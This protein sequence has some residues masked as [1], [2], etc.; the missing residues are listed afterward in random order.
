MATQALIGLA[1]YD[2]V[3]TDIVSMTN[4]NSLYPATNLQTIDPQQV[5]KATGTSSTITFIHGT[6]QRPVGLSIHNHKLAGA[7]VTFAGQ[8]VTIPAR[9]SDGQC[10]NAWLDLRA[11]SIPNTTQHQ[12]VISGASSG[13]GIGRVCI[14]TTLTLLNYQ[15]GSGDVE[16]DVEW[17]STREQGYYGANLIYDR[18]VRL[19]EVKGKTR[20]GTDQA[21]LY[22]VMQAS[23]GQY[24]PFLF[25]PEATAND[26]W[27]ATA[28]KPNLTWQQRTS[29]GK[30]ME[31]EFIIREVSMGLP[32]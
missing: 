4:V 8:S 32:L 3:Y 31:T 15:V 7:T 6:A 16:W 18:G 9:T 14:P 19:R 26:A 10:T 13:F 23:K 2:T 22:A 28:G 20:R 5:A 11:V 27:F 1:S 25:V 24:S 30:V 17:P 12:L 29:A 21:L